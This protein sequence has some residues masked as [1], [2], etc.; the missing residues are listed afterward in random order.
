MFNLRRNIVLYILFFMSITFVIIMGIASCNPSKY[1]TGNFEILRID[2][3]PEVLYI[4][5]D[6]VL[7][8]QIYNPNNETLH[9][10]WEVSGGTL[11]GTGYSVQWHTPSE[12]G[13]YLIELGV[14]G[15]SGEDYERKVVDVNEFE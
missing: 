11:Y 7:T 15:Q 8:A 9:Y 13:S 12:N 2:V 3:N 6:V 1:P 4:N 10:K 14:I 5:M